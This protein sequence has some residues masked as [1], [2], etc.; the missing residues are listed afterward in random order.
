MS[1]QLAVQNFIKDQNVQAMIQKRIGDK[2][3]QFTSDRDWETCLD[4]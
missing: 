1:N 2:V 3:G 4:L